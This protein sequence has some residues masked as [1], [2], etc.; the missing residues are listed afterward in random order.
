[1]ELTPLLMLETV[2]SK[3]RKVRRR[4]DPLDRRVASTLEKKRR[5]RYV[6]SRMK[7]KER[8]E[9]SRSRSTTVGKYGSTV[10]CKA[11]NGFDPP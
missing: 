8:G 10:R 2:K 6:W 7:S 9:I 3:G 4:S 11:Y 1:M 5:E